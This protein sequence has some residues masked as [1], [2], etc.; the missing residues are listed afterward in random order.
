MKA[1]A[2]RIKGCE[3]VL[4][5][6]V[7]SEEL[8]TALDQ[9][10]RR[11]VSKVTISGFR[12]G[13]APRPLLER[14]LGREA[15][16]NEALEHLL[17]EL[18]EQ[19]IKEQGL[20]PFAPPQLELIQL[21]PVVFKATIPT[22]PIV[23]LGDYHRLKLTAEKV[24]T[25]E[26]QIDNSLQQ[27]RHL[28]AVWQPVARPV[29]LDDLVTIDVEGYV[30]AE[31]VFS[32][33]G[34]RYHLLPESPLPAPGFA[35]GLQG[36]NEGEEREFTLTFSPDHPNAELAAKECLFKVSVSEIKEEELP[37]LDD[38]F[39]KSLGQ[40]LET[41]DSLR[42][43]VAAELKA[44]GEAEARRRLEKEVV[45]AVVSLTHVEYPPILAQQELERLLTEHRQQ[46]GEKGLEDYL[47]LS[48]KTEED[49]RSELQPIAER[50]VIRS[51]VLDKVREAENIEVSDAEVEQL[52]LDADRGSSQS[53]SSPQARD[54]LKREL[55]IR[56]TIERLVQI[57]TATP[58]E[59][60]EGKEEP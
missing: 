17:P 60:E 55:L 19:A 48:G 21:D 9:A 14:Y 36:L 52:A 49:L 30:A 53:F 39:A 23:E 37:A 42:Q 41:L 47:K 40:G 38:E 20:E 12:K 46:L 7:E 1:T 16:L 44:A 57:A 51:L 15:L 56:K 59:E 31:K 8:E 10:Y 22:P 13:K 32:E 33:K 35:E 18:Y 11:L 29:R 3:A 26:E 43:R 34:R 24:E 25:T 58:A 4:N 27:L 5:I 45:D 28:Y 54:L 50:I 6:E 2:E